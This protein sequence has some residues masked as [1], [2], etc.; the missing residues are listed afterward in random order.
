MIRTLQEVQDGRVVVTITIDASE[1]PTNTERLYTAAE[2][3]E[4][5]EEWRIERDSCKEAE[6]ELVSARQQIDQVDKDR[7]IER[8]RADKAE[9]RVRVIE[10]RVE[11]MASDLER[12]S[13]QVRFIRDAVRTESVTIAL[14]AIDAET[15]AAPVNEV[16]DKVRRV[17]QLTGPFWDRSDAAEDSTSQA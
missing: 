3:N 7:M 17:R 6:A 1:V 13:R 11:S 16:T 15:Y 12:R 5:Q 4:L 8:D 2:F 14:N 10:A 9:A